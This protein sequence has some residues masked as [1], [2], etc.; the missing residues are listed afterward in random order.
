QADGALDLVIEKIGAPAA[1]LL[2]KV[3]NDG[4]DLER[5]QRAAA[6]LDE[7]GEGKRVDQVALAI[8]ELKKASSCEEKKVVVVK[9]KGL[10]DARALP[11]LRALGGRRLGPLRFGGADT[12]C[13]KDELSEAIAALDDNDEKKEAPPARKTRRGRGR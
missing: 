9:L 13:M 7:I 2:E 3:A 1:D 11:S 4:S 6:A 12:R 10:G 5:R 8:L